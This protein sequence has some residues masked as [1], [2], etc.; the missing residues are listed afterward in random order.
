[1]KLVYE[2]LLIQSWMFYQIS[3]TSFICMYTH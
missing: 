2:M 1:M 3:W